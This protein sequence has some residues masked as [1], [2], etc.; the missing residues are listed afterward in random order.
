M[1]PTMKQGI[2][3]L[4]LVAVL[5]VCVANTNDLQTTLQSRDNRF[6]TDL[7]AVS[8]LGNPTPQQGISS[9]YQISIFNNGT[10]AQSNYQV[11]LFFFQDI[12]VIATVNGTL[13]NP[14][15]TVQITIPWTPQNYGESYI[16][17]KVLLTGD[18]NSANDRTPNFNVVIQPGG[19]IWDWIGDGNELARV[20]VD[21]FYKNSLFECL[22]YPAELANLSGLLTGVKFINNFSTSYL[23]N[24]PTN[25][26][27]GTT[28]LPDLNSGWIPSTQLTQVFSGNVDYPMGQNVIS[29]NFT[30]PFFYTAQQ[31]LVLLMQRPMDTQYYSSNDRFLAQTSP[32]NRARRAFNDNEILNPANPPEGS[33]S[34]LF[35]RTLFTIQPL[36]QVTVSGVVVESEF[37]TGLG[38]AIIHLEGLNNYNATSNAS[39]QFTIPGV[40]ANSTYGY[41]ISCTG[42]QA[43]TGTVTI[44][45]TDYNWGNLTLFPIAYP[46]REVQAEVLENNTQVL[47]SWLTPEFGTL[48]GY[49]VWRL[50]AGEEANEAVWTMITTL[51][52]TEQSILDNAWANLPDGDYLWAVKAVYL[53]S[54]LSPPAFSNI[55]H[56][57]AFSGVLQ[58]TVLST[59]NQAIPGAIIS[60]GGYS[61]TTNNVGVYSLQLPEGVYDITATA[62]DYISQIAESIYIWEGQT[63]TLNF[64]L[65][66]DSAL[67]DETEPVTCT[68]LLGNFP[69]PFN[70]ETTIRYYLH[71]AAHVKLGIYNQKGQLLR[72]L[73]TETKE[74]GDHSILWDGRDKSGTNVSSGIYYYCLQTGGT[75]FTRKMLILK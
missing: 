55:L 45:S 3:T 72:V 30:T 54:V 36:T 27:L 47:I 10:S 75:S 60:A 8:I 25:V 53:S 9:P 44:G 34:G 61:V 1:D 64:T 52:H 67:G 65:Q 12:N 17:A 35:P 21:M 5:A 26:W 24:M 28:A 29:I 32:I 74:P 40:Y 46:P 70:P 33:A 42:Y 6:E 62:T 13:I 63:T 19:V 2:L 48:L 66:S 57:P 73:A 14:G 11:S 23:L 37:G 58:G 41:G 15:E 22:Y 31:N 59:L 68:Q 56:K 43:A 18:Q 7:A 51:L 71:E 49:R 38:G 69:N 20:P 4:A 39:G 16:Y 50:H